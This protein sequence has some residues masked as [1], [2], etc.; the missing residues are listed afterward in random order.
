MFDHNTL[1][2]LTE[3]DN[4]HYYHNSLTNAS[5]AM[6]EDKHWDIWCNMNFTSYPHFCISKAVR[7]F[8][9]RD[10]LFVIDSHTEGCKGTACAAQLT[11]PKR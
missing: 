1:L 11:Q 2:Q 7:I 3:L 8:R 10:V 9:L 4:E 6:G 5:I